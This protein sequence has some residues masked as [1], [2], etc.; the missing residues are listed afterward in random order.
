M[1]RAG[2][3]G[4]GLEG[5]FGRRRKWTRRNRGKKRRRA[6]GG[7]SS[8]PFRCSHF[9]PPGRRFSGSFRSWR[10]LTLSFLFTA[11]E[12]RPFS[13]LRLFFP[14]PLKPLRPDCTFAVCLLEGVFLLREWSGRN[15]RGKGGRVVKEGAG[16][17]LVLLYG[18]GEVVAFLLARAA[19]LVNLSLLPVRQ[20]KEERSFNAHT[21]CGKRRERR[22]C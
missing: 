1:D 7:A 16:G 13:A 10:Y 20:K 12:S 21:L 15:G 19:V 4:G 3:D 5:E 8:L 18:R 2:E 22:A 9:Q 6:V 14:V 17:G 11:Y